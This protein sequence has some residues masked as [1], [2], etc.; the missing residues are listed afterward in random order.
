VP[1]VNESG[2]IEQL[3][4]AQTVERSDVSLGIGD[5]A[6]VTSLAAGCELVISSD[7]LCANT[8][9]PE[10]MSA[11]A[12]G[13]RSLAVNLSDLAAMGAEPLWA[14]LS[15]SLPAGNAQ[16]VKD[17]AAGFC[18][19]AARHDVL[20]IGGDTVRGPLVVSVT[21]H[22]RVVAGSAVK[23]TGA[24]AGQTIFLTGRPGEA[25]AGCRALLEGSST[26]LGE[27][28]SAQSDAL[29]RA[30]MY[31]Q[32]RVR[33][34]L[35]LMGV[36]TS[37]IDVSDGVHVDLQRLLAGSGVGA[38]LDTDCVPLSAAL[39]ASADRDQALELALTGGDDYEL[40]FTVPSEYL[41]ELESAS[42][43]WTCDLNR[44]GETI[45][46]PGIVWMKDGSLFDVPATSFEHF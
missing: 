10:A 5:D 14:T 41:A 8:H 25:A 17:F 12:I 27:R 33:E 2:I 26:V 23:R 16:W 3:I 18:E 38:V 29:T 39:L 7:M 28:A 9:F 1:V 36:A 22:G 4:A 21:V 34:G 37:M 24:G 32:P 31:P 35:S 11:H 42:T 19:L 43:N 6:A 30:F 45:A 44:I 46:D 40:C 20:L 13:H 15:L